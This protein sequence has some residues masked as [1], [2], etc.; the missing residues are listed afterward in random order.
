MTLVLVVDDQD[1]VRAGLAALLRAAPNGYRVTEASDGLE[2]VRLA[3]ELSPEVIL[4]DI[5]MPGMDG[6]TAIQQILAEAEKAERELPRILVLTT[7][8][9]DEHV[10]KALHA[11]ASGFL[12]KSTPAARLF[13]AVDAVAAGDM[14]F[15][16]EITRRLVEAFQQKH[17]ATASAKAHESS[18][19][20]PA[21][22]PRRS[23]E[24]LT[25]RELDVVRMVGTGLSNADIAAELMLAEATVKT[26]IYRV[27]TKLN[28]ASRAQVVVYAYETGLVK[29]GG[30]L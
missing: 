19:A 18:L 17:D 30:R 7:F 29:P 24:D 6:I 1:L 25:S 5:R 2:A 26:H 22:V 12:V 13:A 20:R 9:L 15:T 27:M 4:M 28:L 21:A 8:D 11:G 10:H 16:P 23:A 3:A 14:A